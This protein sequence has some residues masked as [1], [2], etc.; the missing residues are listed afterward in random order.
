MDTELLTFA[1][2]FLDSCGGARPGTCYVASWNVR[3][4]FGI[5]LV[6]GTFDGTC[7]T[8]NV[9]PDGR[10]FDVTHGQFD[11]GPPRFF[12]ADAPGFEPK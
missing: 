11:G 12:P 8:W 7:H 4:E 2:E 9:M 1:E 3:D 5:A 10:I 6:E